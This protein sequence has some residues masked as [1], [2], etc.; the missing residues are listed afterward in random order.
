MMVV[1]HKVLL[2][3]FCFATPLYQGPYGQFLFTVVALDLKIRPRKWSEIAQNRVFMQLMRALLRKNCTDDILCNFAF[4][5][6]S[7]RQD[8][9]AEV[10]GSVFREGKRFR[11][12]RKGGFTEF[13]KSVR[14]DPSKV[15]FFWNFGKISE[16]LPILMPFLKFW[17][18]RV[19][20]GLF[21]VA[22]TRRYVFSQL[23][24]Y[25]ENT[26][27]SPRVNEM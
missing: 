22:K 17:W 1:A 11:A 24:F 2:W 13:Q 3:C 23:I 7:S 16:F 8:W 18:N 15:H 25:V 9:L 4:A 5:M 19:W 26:P 20:V 14:N 27:P 10:V 21:E 6:F 12:G